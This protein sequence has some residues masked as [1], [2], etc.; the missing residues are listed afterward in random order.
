MVTRTLMMEVL[1]VMEL[2][3]IG[4]ELLFYVYFI[5]L[6]FLAE[7]KNIKTITNSFLEYIISTGIQLF[8]V[9]LKKQNSPV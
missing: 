1:K 6:H 8:G 2:E 3:E 7:L 5:V 4:N 9:T